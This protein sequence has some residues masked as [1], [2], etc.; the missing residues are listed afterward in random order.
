MLEK[1]E[2]YAF[3]NLFAMGEVLAASHFAV[4]TEIILAIGRNG[5]VDL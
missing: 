2:M 4:G 5:K 3:P 1:A